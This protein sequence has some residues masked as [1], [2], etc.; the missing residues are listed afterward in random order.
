MSREENFWHRF[1]AV[2]TQAQ[3]PETSLWPEILARIEAETMRRE[4]FSVAVLWMGWRLAPVFVLLCLFVGG[5]ALWGSDDTN[6]L[7]SDAALV[8]LV[9]PDTILSQWMEASE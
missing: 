5:V 2:V 4:S 7:V 6:L 8:S 9:D 3:R 1:F